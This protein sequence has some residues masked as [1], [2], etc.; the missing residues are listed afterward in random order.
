MQRLGFGVGLV[1]NKPFIAN[2][3]HLLGAI[4]DFK[5]KNRPTSCHLFLS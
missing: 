3:I 1:N 5:P 4:S 2:V